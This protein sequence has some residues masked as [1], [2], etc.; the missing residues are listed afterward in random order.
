[1]FEL[2]IDAKGSL[3]PGS[4]LGS[5]ALGRL[6][7]RGGM[8]EVHE[9]VHLGLGKKVAIKTLRPGF[10]QAPGAGERFLREARLTSALRHP[11]V[12]DVTDVGVEGGCTYMVM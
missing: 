4:R 8:A 11:H 2:T 7:G 3:P 6:L 9:A 12:V 5:Y 10:A 1:M